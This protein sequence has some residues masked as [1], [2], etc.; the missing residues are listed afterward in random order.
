[1]S[2]LHIKLRHNGKIETVTVYIALAVDTEGHKDVLG[3]GLEKE[4]NSP[5]FSTVPER[6]GG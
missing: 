2:A 5:P 6:F 1:L 4:R 3:S